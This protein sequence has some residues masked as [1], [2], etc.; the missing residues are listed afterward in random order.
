[1]PQRHG[2]PNESDTMTGTST[3]NR[4]RIRRP[5]RRRRGVR[6]D[7]A[8]AS[9]SSPTPGP[10]F[11]AS[12]PPFA[13]TNPCGVSVMTTPLA[14]RTTRLA[15]RRTTSTWRG[16]RSQRSAKAIASGGA[17]CRSGRRSRP[18]PSRRPSGS[19]RGRRASVSGSG[20]RRP[21]D[22]VADE[23]RQV[24]AVG[25]LR[26][27]RRARGRGSSRQP[28]WRPSGLERL[29]EDQVVG[30]VEVHGERPVELDERGA[31]GAAAASDGPRDCRSRTRRR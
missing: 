11:D 7:A 15:S 5:D 21:L 31:R 28:T 8:A 27:A 9:R 22:G 29:D 2:R 13:Q 1:M 25:D 23:R 26:D 30:R 16:S 3:P 4:S 19:R 18:R 6:I 20:A 14:I 12:M 24:V 10:T 17:R